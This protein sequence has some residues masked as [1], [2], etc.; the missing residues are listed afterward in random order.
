MFMGNE[1]QLQNI[2]QKRDNW[3]NGQETFCDIKSFLN[4]EERIKPCMKT[5]RRKNKLY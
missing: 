2:K 4:T 5:F 1:K 3:H